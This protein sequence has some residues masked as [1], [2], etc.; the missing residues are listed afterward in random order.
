MQEQVQN[1]RNKKN[2]KAEPVL[3]VGLQK[4]GKFYEKS[5]EKR[6]RSIEKDDTGSTT[7][8]FTIV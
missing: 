6:R 1:K 5:N 3:I 7:V 2:G 8:V 4:K